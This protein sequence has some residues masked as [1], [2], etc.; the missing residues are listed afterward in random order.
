M[1]LKEIL[2]RVAPRDRRKILSL[3]V[4][5]TTAEEIKQ[6]SLANGTPISD[7]EANFLL[8]LKTQGMDRTRE[9]QD[10]ELD[11][12]SGGCG[13]K[14][15]EPK[16]YHKMS[17]GELQEMWRDSNQ[18]WADHLLDEEYYGTFFEYF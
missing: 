11:N 7:E 17:L 14:K 12:V 18:R 1:N 9:L 13:G 4:K 6:T 2:G 3:W 10:D 15:E 16:A 5:C 8:E